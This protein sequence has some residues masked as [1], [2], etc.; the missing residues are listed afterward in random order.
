M[1]D[2]NVGCPVQADDIALI[3]PTFSGMQCMIDICYNY[4]VKW[5]FEFSPS[6][7]QVLIFSKRTETYRDLKL[8]TDII[9]VCNS[10]KHVGI[11]LDAR[12]NSTERTLAACR[13]IRSVCMSI[14]RMGVHPSLLNPITCSKIIVQLCYSKGLYGCELWN[15]LTKHELLLLERTHRYICKYVQG[16]PRLTR[17]DKCTSLLGWI[18]I[19]SIININKLLFFGRLCNM[20]FKYLLDS[21]NDFEYFK[22]IHNSIEPYRAWTILR[23]YPSLNFQAKFVI[24]L[25]VLVWTSEPNA[26]LLLCHKCC[27]SMTTQL[28]TF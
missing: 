15:N 13:T 18:P 7:S 1:L 27:F 16:L 10:V 23:Q 9:P 11:I 17:T 21:D 8:N 14:I 22:L 19:E 24:S 12:F 4:S 25:C 5:K 2:L 6:K 3:S 20:P 26:E 28:C